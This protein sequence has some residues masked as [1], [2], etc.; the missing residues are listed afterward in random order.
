MY[1]DDLVLLSKTETWMQT[2]LEKLKRYSEMRHLEINMKK[3]KN[4]DIA[5]KL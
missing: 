5:Q 3:N 4:T 2:M 1:P